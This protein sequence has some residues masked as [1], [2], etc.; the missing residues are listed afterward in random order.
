MQNVKNHQVDGFSL[1]EIM[2]A[3]FIVGIMGA[4]GLISFNGY[5][6][7]ASRSATETSLKTL[8]QQISLFQ[9]NLGAYPTRLED[10]AERPKGD[11]GAKWSQFIE[12]VPQDGWGQK[13]VYKVTPGGK[14]PYQLYSY[15]GSEGPNED[16][17]KRIDVWTSI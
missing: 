17:E 13:F 3:L 11:L 12:K 5:R 16:P 14:H 2:I 1:I 6:E 7:R 15:G 8:K 9:M 10:L 4:V